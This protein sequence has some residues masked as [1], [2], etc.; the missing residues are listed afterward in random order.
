MFVPNPIAPPLE[1]DG[2][3]GRIFFLDNG[4][5]KTSLSGKDFLSASQSEDEGVWFWSFGDIARLAVARSGL[6]LALLL[7]F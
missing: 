3:A 1:L 5:W 6:V 2:I 4:V 7:V